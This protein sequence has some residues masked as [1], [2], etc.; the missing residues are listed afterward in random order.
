M[1]RPAPWAQSSE[2][3]RWLLV[4]A[5]TSVVVR[6]K[7]LPSPVSVRPRP[8]RLDRLAA[9]GAGKPSAAGDDR[10]LDYG[11]YDAQS[12]ALLPPLT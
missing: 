1:A 11:G 2:A 9:A 10:R 7:L 4:T 6:V 8:P 5:F 12:V 3:P